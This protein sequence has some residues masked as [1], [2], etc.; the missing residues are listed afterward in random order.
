M[1]RRTDSGGLLPPQNLLD[2]LAATFATASLRNRVHGPN[3]GVHQDLQQV[4]FEPRINPL[5]LL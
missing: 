1:N 4:I 3:R 5:S 2:S